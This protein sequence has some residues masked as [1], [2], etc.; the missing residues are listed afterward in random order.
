MSIDR[1]VRADPT[2]E[3]AGDDDNGNRPVEAAPVTLSPKWQR[4]ICRDDI[5]SPAPEEMFTGTDCDVLLSLPQQG[6]RRVASR[7]KPL[8]EYASSPPPT[9]APTALPD[10]TSG[11][12]DDGRSVMDLNPRGE[13]LSDLAVLLQPVSS[14]RRHMSQ[15]ASQ[16]LRR[17]EVSG[18]PVAPR[19]PG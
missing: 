17:C 13:A 1:R 2:A 14:H 10:H 11:S 4:P 6:A 16:V 15:G 7:R 9:L 12:G 8:K 18:A 3:E 5:E 19:S